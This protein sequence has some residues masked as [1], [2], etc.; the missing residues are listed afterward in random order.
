MLI[1]TTEVLNLLTSDLL[2]DQ[3]ERKK[4]SAWVQV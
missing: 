3:L 4:G 2:F 1:R